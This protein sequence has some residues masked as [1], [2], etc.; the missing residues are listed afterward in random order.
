MTNGQGVLRVDQSLSR[1]PHVSW[2]NASNYKKMIR[3][4]VNHTV[5]CEISSYSY[6][7]NSSYTS[8]ILIEMKRYIH[9]YKIQDWMDK[10][11]N[12]NHCMKTKFICL[13]EM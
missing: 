13:P 2:L 12:R 6:R 10:I 11:S 1:R 9:G 4:F 5:F 8:S 3:I 7:T